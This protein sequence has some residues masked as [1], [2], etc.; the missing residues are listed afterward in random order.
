MKLVQ[1][2][3]S[4][5]SPLSVSD[6]RETQG[7]LHGL[8]VDGNCHHREPSKVPG[9]LHNHTAPRGNGI[10]KNKNQR[11]P[12]RD[13]EVGHPSFP[14]SD[15]TP[16]TRKYQDSPLSLRRKC[17]FTS[18][19]PLSLASVSLRRPLLSRDAKQCMTR[20]FQRL[21]GLASDI[22]TIASALTCRSG[23]NAVSSSVG[24]DGRM[25]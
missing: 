25:M 24:K 20:V 9:L 10:E 7:Y 3:I 17:I 18:L 23:R 21:L 15:H 2:D 19:S 6:K 13:C 11:V 1:V 12:T 5:Q 16:R 4:G 22:G 8:T 14:F